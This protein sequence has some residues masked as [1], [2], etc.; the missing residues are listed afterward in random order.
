MSR[1]VLLYVCCFLVTFG[2]VVVKESKGEEV[3]INQHFSLDEAEVDS[4]SKSAMLGSPSSAFRL[5]EYYD[6]VESDSIKARDWLH[7]AAE[8]GHVTAQYNYAMLL[9]LEEGELYQNRSLYWIKLAASKGHERALRKLE[10]M[11]K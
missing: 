1:N 6:L 7:I 4:L 9:S 10:A 8:N 5:F 2:G 3:F 11:G